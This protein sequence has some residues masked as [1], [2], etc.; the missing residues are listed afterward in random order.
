MDY[1]AQY[2]TSSARKIDVHHHLM[3]DFWL[4]GIYVASLDSSKAANMI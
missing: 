2:S 4:E 3:P 1:T